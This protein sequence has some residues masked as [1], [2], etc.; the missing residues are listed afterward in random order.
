MYLRETLKEK[1]AA[2]REG[3]TEKLDK[4]LTKFRDDTIKRKVKLSQPET[5]MES[6]VYRILNKQKSGS[7]IYKESGVHDLDWENKSHQ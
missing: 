6:G 5:R 2:L 3:G 7:G 4:W 1:L